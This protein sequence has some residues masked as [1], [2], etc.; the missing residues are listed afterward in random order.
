MTIVGEGP[1]LVLVPGMQGRWEWMEP[2]VEALAASFR[3]ATFSLCGEPGAPRLGG[4]FDAHLTQVDA[5]IDAL[6]GAPVVLVG[7]SFGGWVALRYAARFPERVRTLVV[8][9]TPGPRFRLR[10]QAARWVRH[11][12][13]SLPEFVLTSPIRFVPEVRAATG[14]AADAARFIARHARRVLSAPMSASR[15]AARLQLA[16]A[17]DFDDEARRVTAPTLVVTG[18]DTLDRVVPAESTREYVARIRG[19]RLAQIERTG[20]MGTITRPD[21]FA[22]MVRAFAGNLDDERSSVA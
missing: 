4:D 15:A 19:A 12:R 17:I 6:G 8:A 22:A 20:H 11:P 1:P 5:A 13:L 2:T 18:E 16:F 21:R 9:S 7:V 10:P 14:G 3:V